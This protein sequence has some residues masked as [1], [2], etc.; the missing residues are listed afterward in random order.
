MEYAIRQFSELPG[1]GSLIPFVNTWA[2]GVKPG[3]KVP[4]IL[5][6]SHRRVFV[7]RFVEERA[8]K[9]YAWT[10]AA[11]WEALEGAAVDAVHEQGGSVT[12]RALYLC[13]ADLAHR[14]SFS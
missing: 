1:K 10:I 14:A 6:G 7:A 9:S 2:E 3:D 4:F 13:P 5:V 11:N 12:D 8:T